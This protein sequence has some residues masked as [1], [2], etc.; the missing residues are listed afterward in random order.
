MTTIITKTSSSGAA[1][2]AGG[3]VAQP[4]ANFVGGL[5]GWSGDCPLQ[6]GKYTPDIIWRTTIS[7]LSSPNYEVV[8]VMQRK[9]KKNKTLEACL[10]MQHVDFCNF[11]LAKRLHSQAGPQMTAQCCIPQ[12]KH[13]VDD[14]Y[15]HP[16]FNN[17]HSLL[18]TQS[19]L[20][21]RKSKNL[22]HPPPILPRE[23]WSSFFYWF[24]IILV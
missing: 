22:E 12:V 17:R 5:L 19:S 6:N 16:F 18:A 23:I 11:L 21:S 24:V 9:L 10:R 20:D 3:L 15:L 4:A 7:R 2:F 8:R 13:W 1:G 14:F